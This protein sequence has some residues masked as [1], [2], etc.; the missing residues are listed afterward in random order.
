MKD[1]TR[2][3]ASVFILSVLTAKSARTEETAVLRITQDVPILLL[4]FFVARDVGLWEKNGVSVTPVPSVIGMPNLIAVAGG[5]IDVGISSMGAT[6]I[7]ALNNAA[8]KVLGSFNRFEAMELTCSKEIKSPTD[9]PGKKIA[10]LQG[11]DSQYYLHLLTKKYNIAKSSFTTVRLN[12]AEMVSAL[13]S[14]AID[15]F[16]WQE[17]FLSKAVATNPAKFHRLAEPDLQVLNA[18]A[19]TSERVWTEKKPILVKA[20][21]AIGQA[22]QYVQSNP[23]EAV[24]I[25]ARSAQIEPSIAAAALSRMDVSLALDIPVYNREMQSVAQWAVADGVVRPD[26]RIPDFSSFFAPDVFAQ[27]TQS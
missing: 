17:P 2:R 5:S 13:A 7:A 23:N 15:G 19:T 27:A 20:L 18:F 11:T 22:C 25:G 3:A 21:R 1:L 24:A 4:P 10:V 16:V 6:T 8:I 14:G 12:P 26:L 9:I